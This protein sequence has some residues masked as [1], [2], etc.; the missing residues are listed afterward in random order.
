MFAL[1]HCFI[2]D[3]VTPSPAPANL[4]TPSPPQVV[5]STPDSLDTSLTSE[6]ADVGDVTDDAD[7]MEHDEYKELVCSKEKN[8]RRVVRYTSRPTLFRHKRI[9]KASVCLYAAVDDGIRL[10][11]TGIQWSIDGT[12]YEI[13]C[14]ASL[15]WVEPEKR[16]NSH[17]VS[18]ANPIYAILR[19]GSLQGK[20]VEFLHLMRLVAS[21]LFREGRP[22]STVLTKQVRIQ[23]H[24]ATDGS[25]PELG[26]W[27]WLAE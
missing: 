5:V 7:Y 1:L 20:P 12:V 3:V 2:L 19:L 26:T 23:L 27:R 17:H 11:Q 18:Y 22:L 15:G 9:P 6:A 14:I 8:F 10:A 25:N 13:V 16:R 4:V 21:V 24:Q